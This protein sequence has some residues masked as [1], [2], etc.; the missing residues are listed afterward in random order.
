M[1][2]PI[3][4]EPTGSKQ[5][6]EHIQEPPDKPMKKKKWYQSKKLDEIELDIKEDIEDFE[7]DF[8]EFDGWESIGFHRSLGKELWQI[9]IELITTSLGLVALNFYMPLLLPFPEIGGYQN[10]AGGLFTLVYT[11]FDLGTNFGL[12]RFVA[13]YR[14]KDTRRMMQYVSYVFWYQSFT[15]LIQVTLLSWYVFEVIV[16]NNFAFLAWIMLLQL[17]KVQYPGC[18]GI[19]RGVLSGMQHFN[20]VETLNIIQGQIV[21]RFTLIGIVIAFRLWG[22]N[23][24]S[25]GLMMGIIF[26]S[27]IGGH[28]DD[29]IFTFI[30]IYFL[31]KILKKYYGMNVGDLLEIHYDK[32]VLK[33]II[34]YG[35]QA[36]IF[37]FIHNFW[38]LWILFTYLDNV[39]AYYTWQALI[40]TGMGLAAQ[41]GQFGDFS[42]RTSIAE[43]Y[44]SKKITLSEFHI[45]YSVRWRMCLMLMLAMIIIGASPF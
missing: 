45:S 4:E 10:V 28:I 41:M 24:I 16:H 39:N 27:I 29:V 6:I 30:G 20:K 12:D 18:L 34:F 1:D 36:S 17:V 22:E 38:N 44:P 43:A 31:K 9:I 14:V 11:I 21:E 15:G 3:L 32:G 2:E 40:G 7:K 25:Y 5:E 42:L 26:G 35:L 23:Q 13:E 8:P 19:F 33:D 37:P